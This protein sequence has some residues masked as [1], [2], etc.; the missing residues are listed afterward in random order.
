MSKADYVSFEEVKER[1]SFE[2]VCGLLGIKLIPAGKGFRADCIFCEQERSMGIT[3][4]KNLF[5]CFKCHES[6]DQ[7][8]LYAKAKGLSMKEGAIAL[9]TPHEVSS[10][11]GMEPLSYLEFDHPSIFVLGFEDEVAHQL[12]IGYASKGS[13]KGKVCVPIRLPNGKLVGYLGID[14]AQLPKEWHL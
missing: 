12:G 5:H 10:S 2:Q 9:S 8:A 6:G 4:S 1:V 7:I 3:P 13:M 14:D 11:E